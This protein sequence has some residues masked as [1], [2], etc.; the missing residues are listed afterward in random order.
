MS[1]YSTRTPSQERLKKIMKLIFKLETRSSFYR[2][3]EPE[4]L[5]TKE[6]EAVWEAIKLWDIGMFYKK[7]PNI[8][9]ASKLPMPV[10][11][12]NIGLDVERLYSGATGNNVRQILDALHP[13][14]K[15]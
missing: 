2:D 7:D 14:K 9:G 8:P 5:G 6:F 11:R 15:L 3:P 13:Q 4:M 12:G 10:K 1:L